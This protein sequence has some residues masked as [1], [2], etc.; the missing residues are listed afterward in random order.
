MSDRDE[1]GRFATGNRLWEARSSAGPKPIFENSDDL[2]GACVEYFQWVEENPLWEQRGFAFQGKVTKEDF[3]KMRAMTIGALCIF[4]D[5]NETTWRGWKRERSDLS[6]VI[7][8]VEAIIFA[9]KFEGASAELLN[10]NIIARELGL[11]DKQELT[12]KDRGPIQTQDVTEAGLIEQATRLGFDPKL[13]G[14][15]GSPQ[16]DN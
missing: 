14:L 3:S 6:P 10:P 7:T 5:I 2:W 13:L 9:Q 8:R 12:G 4:L 16:E 11:S 15:T 1:A